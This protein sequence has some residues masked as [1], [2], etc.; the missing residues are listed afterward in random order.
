MDSDLSEFLVTGYVQDKQRHP[1]VVITC[2]RKKQKERLQAIIRGVK[3]VNKTL[4]DLDSRGGFDYKIPDLI[5]INPGILIVVD[6][7]CQKLGEKIDV[8]QLIIDAGI[9]DG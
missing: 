6:Q 5:S 1:L 3:F 9:A 4:G 7:D 2:D 8:R